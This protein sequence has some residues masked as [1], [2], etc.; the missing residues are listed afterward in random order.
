MNYIDVIGVLFILVV[1]TVCVLFYGG[2]IW[3][4]IQ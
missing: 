4:L 3:V 1:I 2:L